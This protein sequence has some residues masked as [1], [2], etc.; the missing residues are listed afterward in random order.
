[1]PELIGARPLA[2]LVARVARRGAEEG[3]G[4]T[5]VPVQDSPGV[6]RQRSGITSVVKAVAGRVPVWVA[7]GSEMGQGG[8]GVERWE[9]G[10]PGHPFIGSE[11]EQGDHAS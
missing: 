11:G 9:E 6:G 10:M 5:G 1:V 8:T 4:S 2:T 7:R 3:N